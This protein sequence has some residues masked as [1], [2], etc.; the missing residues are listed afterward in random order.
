V[1]IGA[2]ALTVVMGYLL[3]SIPTGFVLAR[4]KGV[5]IRT[6]GSG[7][8]GATNVMRILGKPLGILVLFFDAAKGWVSCSWVPLFVMRSVGGEG[9]Q[10]E[11]ALV[12]LAIAGGIASI[13]G[14]NYTCWLRFRGGKGIATTAGVMLG[15][16]PLALLVVLG[17][18]IAVVALSR[19]V[20]LGSTV[21]AACLPVSVWWL[22]G[23]PQVV[24]VAALLAALA[25]YKHRS[26]IQ[27]LI[28]GTENRIGSQR[29]TQ[30]QQE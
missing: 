17:I 1:G 4:A 14:H 2:Y 11:T 20:S 22:G 10:G 8:I 16:A 13:L 15:L 27:R 29:R 18:W 28:Q 21:A 25:I 26:N 12:N 30:E 5:D 6:M 23:L 24:V 19:Y 3:G 9:G 7:N